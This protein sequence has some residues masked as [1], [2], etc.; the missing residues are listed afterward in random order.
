MNEDHLR[1]LTPRQLELVNK[2]T[3]YIDEIFES[4]RGKEPRFEYG[5]VMCILTSIVAKY[6][7]YLAGKFPLNEYTFF[8]HAFR[9][10]F[11]RQLIEKMDSSVTIL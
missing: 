1:D 3:P 6:A 5:D 10:E 7:I 11:N 2:I 8:C 9:S 4:Q